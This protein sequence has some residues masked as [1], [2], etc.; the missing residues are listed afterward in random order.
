MT[1]DDTS[2]TCAC[3]GSCGCQDSQSTAHVHLTREEY[4]AQLEQYLVDLRSEIT[5]VEKE[6]EQVKGLVPVTALIEV[7]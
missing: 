4:I 6:L 7:A 1:H 5:L 3:G 2:S